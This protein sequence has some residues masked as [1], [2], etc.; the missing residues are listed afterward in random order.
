MVCHCNM[1][2]VWGNFGGVRGMLSKF[3]SFASLILELVNGDSVSSSLLTI[4]VFAFDMPQILLQN[5][6]HSFGSVSSTLL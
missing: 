4:L 3:I 2:I 5:D 6:H 1:D